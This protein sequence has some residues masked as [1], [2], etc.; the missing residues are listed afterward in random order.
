MAPAPLSVRYPVH[1]NLRCDFWLQVSSVQDPLIINDKLVELLGLPSLADHVTAG[2]FRG[3]TLLP[4]L[5][6][7]STQVLFN[8]ANQQDG[9]ER[10]T[11]LNRHI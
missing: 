1:N 3:G 2:W 7:A 10:S 8:L 5:S 11:R 6:A 4:F 9:N